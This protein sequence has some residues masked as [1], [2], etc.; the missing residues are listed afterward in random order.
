MKVKR[1]EITKICLIF[2]F[3]LVSHGPLL[4]QTTVKKIDGSKAKEESVKWSSEIV[5][6]Y[7]SSL[8]KT[9]SIDY[10]SSADFEAT[11]SALF[12]ET[13][14]SL[15]ASATK[16]LTNQ[17]EL[18]LNNAS[19][20]AARSLYKFNDQWSS[21]ASV[22]VTIPL[23]EAAKDYQ[24][25]ITG[26][27]LTPSLKWKS[28]FGLSLGYAPNAQVNFHKY[29]NSVTGSSNYQYVLGNSLSATYLTSAGLYAYASAGY[30]RLT[31]YRGNSK[32]SYKF[33][34]LIG[35]PVGKYD[36]AIGH[37]IGGSPLAANG[38]E[39]DVRLFD[40]RSSTVFGMLTV[41]F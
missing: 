31:T 41:S 17:R 29:K 39:T 37:V 14:F 5:T 34:Q 2:T 8:N 7:A 36:F 6:T 10:S 27:S 4:A 3:L 16:E 25:Q 15:T 13:K 21:A 20:A 33:L 40:S 23:S 35:Y 1:I 19:L 12:K 18:N 26:V 24:R 11:L 32:D 38:I 28:D 30:S 22:K 9:D